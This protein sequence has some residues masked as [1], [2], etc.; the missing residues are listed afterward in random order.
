MAAIAARGITPA[1]PWYTHHL[2]MVP[3]IFDFEARVPVTTRT[4]AGGRVQPSQWP[5]MRM[6][7]TI[8]HGGY[9]GHGAAWGEFNA[10]IAANR[11]AP[12][13]DYWECYVA[14]PARSPDPAT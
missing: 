8:F 6:V 12:A 9:E 7:R 1:G 5:A 2:R 11:H 13:A 3:N 14:G 10:W 4:S